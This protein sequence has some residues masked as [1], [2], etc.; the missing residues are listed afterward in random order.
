MSTAEEPRA[1]APED[2]ENKP[3]VVAKPKA[4]N[5]L[6]GFFKTVS[7]EEYQK[8]M[9]QSLGGP[10]LITVQAE[11]HGETPDSKKI[12]VWIFH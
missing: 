3:P 1:K 10:K 9:E 11:V 8:K 2:E 7:K 6:V 5:A 12:K 4:K